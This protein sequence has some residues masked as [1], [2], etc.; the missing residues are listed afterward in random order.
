LI[1]MLNAAMNTPHNY[2]FSWADASL[3]IILFLVAAI[4]SGLAIKHSDT[5]GGRI[6][7]R[8]LFAF[9]SVFFFATLWRTLSHV[10]SA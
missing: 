3:N 5:I 4:S 9:Y 1:G 8:I 2:A 7:F 10:V 6:A